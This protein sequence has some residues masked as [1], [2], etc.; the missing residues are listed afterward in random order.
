MMKLSSSL[1]P[2]VVELER[3][4]ADQVPGGPPPPRSLYSGEGTNNLTVV[5]QLQQLF[6]AAY[7]PPSLQPT[8][9]TSC[10]H[11]PSG[12]WAK[13][14]AVSHTL[15]PSRRKVR[16]CLSVR[17]LVSCPPHSI[18]QFH[19]TTATCLIPPFSVVCTLFWNQ[20]AVSE[21]PSDCE[22]CEETPFFFQ[23]VS[24]SR[25]VRLRAVSCKC[26]LRQNTPF[27]LL[28]SAPSSFLSAET[29]SDYIRS[30]SSLSA[31]PSL[32]NSGER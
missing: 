28:P 25:R 15:S 26:W 30:F 11:V 19:Q 18:W 22:R 6:S 9:I 2:P 5:I 24:V 27:L 13:C 14:S 10:V 17:T 1:F 3:V 4:C 23:G 8:K 16:N 20:S 31:R 29:V 32:T 12:S 7:A 21:P